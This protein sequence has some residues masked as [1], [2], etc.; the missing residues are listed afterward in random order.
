MAVLRVDHPDI[1]RFI[2]AKD[3]GGL[4][5]FN[6]SVGLTDVFM[7]AVLEGGPWAL[8]HRGGCEVL[9]SMP[10]RAL[11][12]QLVHAAWDHGDPGVLFLDTLARENPL[13]SIETLACTNPC[14]EQPLPPYGACCLGALDLTRFVHRPFHP[15]ARIDLPALA[16]VAAVGVRM[17][18]NVIDLTL[19]P[20]PAHADEARSKR[21][22]G[23]GLTGLADALILLN[24]PYDS[25]PARAQAARVGR[26]LREAAVRASTAL[27]REKGPF[28]RFAASQYLAS[29]GFAARLPAALRQRIASHGLRNSHL[30]SI[31]PCGTISLAMADVVSTGVEP[32]VDWVRPRTL[33][34]PDGVACQYDLQDSAWRLWRALKGS[35][36][37]LPLAF[38]TVRD[39]GP[40]D[41]VAMV[42]ALAPF[43]DGGISK[44]VNLPAEASSADVEAVFRSAWLRG[45]KGITVFRPNPLTGLA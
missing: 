11:W 35:Q 31:A 22:I 16:R 42:A 30:L 40:E 5:H 43:I 36:A 20:L 6:L 25:A 26:T 45:L 41:Q 24:L 21:R 4:R 28:P 13:S 9:A 14:G 8:T 7:R 19:W 27:A 33:R 18:D 38:R 1:E 29:P 34:G 39:I 23:L 2:H 32:V 10:A 44:T 15:D 12:E 3:H 17:L 37:A